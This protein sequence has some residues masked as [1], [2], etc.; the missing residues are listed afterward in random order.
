MHNF[1]LITKEIL[2]GHPESGIEDIAEM[3]RRSPTMNEF[4]KDKRV[5]FTK[6]KCP[7]YIR[8]SDVSGLHN[9][10]SVRGWMEIPSTTKKWIQWGSY[11]EWFE[12]YSVPESEHHLAHFFDHFLRGVENGFET[13]TPKVRWDALQY[14][15]GRPVHDIVLEDFPVP[16]TDYQDLFL[17]ENGRLSSSPPSQT[18][19]LTYNSEDRKSVL[20]FNHTFTEPS[21]LIGLPK[22]E[23]Y[24]SCE[25]QD[26]FVVFVLL[27]KK[28]KDGNDMMHLNFPF[29]ASPIK[30]MAEIDTKSTHSVNTW[31][32]PMGVLRASRRAIDPKRSIHPNFP[33][34]PHEKEEK[35]TPG[36]VVK[37]EIG[38]WAIGTDYEA[39]ESISLRISGQNPTAAEFNAWS[40]PRPEHELNHGE[41][42]VYFGGEYPSK[43]IIPHIGKP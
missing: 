32:G 35:I 11:Q 18:Q 41:H 1:D 5:D 16:G 17:S 23:I 7:T 43:I 10:G 29:E 25:A 19:T 27:R 15:D 3:Y 28:D 24:I 37:L 12:L 8:G 6:I 21:R 4:W 31:I 42:K 33:F 26:D 36:D 34:H 9:M 14:G 40:K 20:E 2:R 22:A 30:S 13:D 39:G 38:I